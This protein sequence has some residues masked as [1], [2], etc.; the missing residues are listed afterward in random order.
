MID[1]PAD[2]TVSAKG[3]PARQSFRLVDA[4]ILIAATA[5]GLAFVRYS[6]MR[7]FVWEK[8]EAP[9]RVIFYTLAAIGRPVYGTLPI[10]YGLC[11]AIVA[12]VL[13]GARPCREEFTLRPGLAAC[14]AALV[15]LITAAV[16]RLLSYAAG[17]P[18][19]LWSKQPLDVLL[20]TADTYL[21]SPPA[22]DAL[23]MDA[24]VG[25]I[26]AVLAV[27]CLQRLCGLWHPVPEW[28]DRL[29]RA[30]GTVLLLW[31]LTPH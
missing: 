15:A 9:D 20:A 6:Q 26:S 19:V 23:L 7:Y 17:N 8:P 14:A 30:L 31:A 28:P 25:S 27:W 3:Q 29:G 18:G 1:A 5:V 22:I 4:M 24:G 16:V 2:Q 12:T 13:R 21:W 10:L 11:A